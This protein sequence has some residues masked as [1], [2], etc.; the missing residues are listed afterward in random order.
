MFLE[1][2]LIARTQ[3]APAYEVRSAVDQPSFGRFVPGPWRDRAAVEYF[4]SNEDP[5]LSGTRVKIQDRDGRTLH[6]DRVEKGQAVAAYDAKGAR[7]NFHLHDSSA[8]GT[9]DGYGNPLFAHG[10]RFF[11]MDPLLAVGADGRVATLA[12]DS[13]RTA[14]AAS[15]DGKTLLTLEFEGR[16]GKLRY[17]SRPGEWT[18]REIAPFPENVGPGPGLS[19]AL[20]SYGECFF[21]ARLADGETYADVLYRCDIRTG[22]L[23]TVA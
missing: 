15:S 11:L 20:N 10:Y 2:P 21:F 1:L 12:G 4:R 9:M 6:D 17:S 5:R 7:Q 8:P 18:T 19:L 16:R 3:D 14:V 23:A 13:F 22:R